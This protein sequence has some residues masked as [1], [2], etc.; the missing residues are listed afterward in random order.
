MR[1]PSACTGVAPGTQSCAPRC[2]PTIRRRCVADAR[3]TSGGSEPSGGS[4]RPCR[5]GEPHQNISALLDDEPRTGL[6]DLPAASSH[7]NDPRVRDGGSWRPQHR[8]HRANPERLSGQSNGN[9]IAHCPSTVRRAPSGRT[10]SGCQL[11]PPA[12]VVTRRIR[13]CPSRSRRLVVP[14]VEALS[15]ENPRSWPPHEALLGTHATP[16]SAGPTRGTAEPNRCVA[17]MATRAEGASPSQSV[18][19]NEARLP[20]RLV[21]CPNCPR[22]CGVPPSHD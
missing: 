15:A 22:C 8:V 10:A 6:H 14:C 17:A 12:S 9:G 13:S 2:W 21:E 20:Q 11:T 5:R 1:H 18:G 16:V 4:R 19:R 3:S 7:H